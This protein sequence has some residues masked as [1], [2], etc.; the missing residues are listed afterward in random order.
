MKKTSRTPDRTNRRKVEHIE[1]INADRDVDR[2]KFYFDDIQL[3]HR[4]LPEIDLDA[5]DTSTTFMGKRLALPLLISS[6]TGGDHAM[7]RRINRHLAEAAERCGV[8]MGVG[9]QRVMFTHPNARASFALRAHAP[10]ALLFANLGAVQLNKGF[11]IDHCREAVQALEADG[12]YL[13]LNPLQEAVQ[14]EGDTQFGGLADKIGAVAAALPQPLIVKEVGAGVSREDVELLL[15]RGVR[16]IDVAGSG[17]TSWSRIEHHRQTPSGANAL[18]LLYQDWGLPTPRA[19]WELRDLR[20]RVTLIASGGLRSGLDMAKAI[21]L[22]ASLC[23]LAAPFLKPA[24]QSADAVVEV[25]DRLHREFRVAMFL[26][27]VSRVADLIGNTRLLQ[28]PLP[29]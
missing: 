14:P 6:M 1:I 20:P 17:G 2:R 4:A 23:G 29:L 19:L 3:R 13:H 7:V 9:S 21:V 27:G 18:G 24:M 16:F 28:N 26:L 5:V 15:P 10:T 25:I 12:L 11:T 8:A 22:G